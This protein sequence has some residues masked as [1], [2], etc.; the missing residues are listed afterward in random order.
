MDRNESS[1]VSRLQNVADLDIFYGIIQ[2]ER[3]SVWFADATW[4][5]PCQLLRARY[6]QLALV[7]EGRVDFCRV[8]ADQAATI[9]SVLNVQ[10]MPST[11]VFRTGVALDWPWPVAGVPTATLKQ[12]RQ[13][14]DTH[15][16]TS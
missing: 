13:W 14:L 4:C 5:A 12:Y 10:K 1:A 7:Y 6:E 15:M 9:I 2:M 16:T 11:Y 3:L 8:D